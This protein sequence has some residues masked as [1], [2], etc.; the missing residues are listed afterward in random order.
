MKRYNPGGKASDVYNFYGMAVAFSMVDA[1]RRAGRNLTRESLLRAAT[2]MDER[3]NPFLLPGVA[4]RTSPSNYFPITKA[5]LVRYRG[6]RWVLFGPL[7]TA[8]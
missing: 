3:G 4:V 5:K 2:H 6:T 1:L 7:V 8:R